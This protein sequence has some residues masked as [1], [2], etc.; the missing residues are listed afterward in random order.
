MPAPRPAVAA[1]RRSGQRIGLGPPAAARRWRRALGTLCLAG[2]AATGGGCSAIDAVR[3][4]GADR[5][6]ALEQVPQAPRLPDVLPNPA[7][8]H[9]PRTTLGFAPRTIRDADAPVEHWDVSLQEA[10]AFAVE[11]STVARDLGAAVLRNP[12]SVQTRFDPALQYTDA[13]FGPE[14]ALAEF[15]AQFTAGLFGQNNDRVINN[16]FA[17]GGVQQFQQDLVT[18][19]A[20]LSK[21]SATGTRFALRQLTE[22][23]NNNA[24]ANLFP[25][26]YDTYAE[27]EARHPLL[28]GGGVT[29]NRIAG[30][31]GEPGFYNG[32]VI[33]RVNH[34][35]SQTEFETGL[36]DFVSDVTNAYWELVYA[37]RNLNAKRQARDRAVLVAEAFRDRAEGL[38][39]SDAEKEA[40]VR[41][42]YFR[43]QEEVEE[44]LAGRPIEYTFTGAGRGGGTFRGGGG[45]QTAERRLRLLMGVPLNEPRALRPAEDGPAVPAEVLFDWGTIAGR[46][47]DARPELRAQRLRVRRAEMELT[48]AQNFLSP[49]LDAVARYRVRGFGDRLVSAAEGPPGPQ[50]RGSEAFE[51]LDSGDFQEWEAGLEFSVPLGFRRAHAAVQNAELQIARERALLREQ[52]RQVMYDLSNAVAEKDRAYQSLQTSLNRHAAAVELLDSL[53]NRFGLARPTLEGEAP[54]DEAV[55]GVGDFGELDRLLD[56][57]RRV[58]DSELAVFSAKAAYEVAIKNVFFETGELLQYHEVLLADG[59]AAGPSVSAPGDAFAPPAP[60]PAPADLLPAPAPLPALDDAADGP[61]PLLQT[62]PPTFL[63][64][65]PL[66]PPG[67]DAP[68]DSDA[69][70]SPSTNRP[71]AAA[72]PAEAAPLLE[73]AGE[74]VNEPAAAAPAGR[75]SL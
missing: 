8:E 65:D 15:D 64:E 66:P 1:R 34:E 59:G 7:S 50:L 72:P 22:Y 62:D 20:E 28:R 41:E 27:A 10:I 5:H 37:Y 31:D 70:T 39:G 75:A 25:S 4:T 67:G 30:P 11:N 29:F 52:E 55:G 60:M 19:R 32:V 40:L 69:E 56:A 53:E 54:D 23:D 49:Q 58:T 35:I 14:A 26:A 12:D 3:L 38:G 61:A 18:S 46:A 6:V 13:R 17:G 36:R 74:A 43:F 48:A 21:V 47:L 9:D 33:A 42:Q 44:A 57:Q 73:P 51:T 45:V 24:P 71:A 63:P 2:L 68:V 16:Q